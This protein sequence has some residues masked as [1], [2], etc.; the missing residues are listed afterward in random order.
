ML[1][2]ER[3]REKG[4]DAAASE[5]ICA[6]PIDFCFFL[7]EQTALGV[8]SFCNTSQQQ[9]QQQQQKEEANDERRGEDYEEEREE[10]G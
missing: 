10:K 5:R 6:S 3:E 8:F 4:G 2:I 9:Q 7:S 1:L